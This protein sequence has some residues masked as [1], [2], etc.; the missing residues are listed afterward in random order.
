MKVWHGYGSEHSH[1]LVLI[2]TFGDSESASEAKR[3]IDRLKSQATAEW[4]QNVKPFEHRF[5]DAMM[6]ILSEENLMTVSPEE[7]EQLAYD[8]NVQLDGKTITVTTDEID[9]FGFAKVMIHK[10]ASIQMYSA[11]DYPS[12]PPARQDN[13]ND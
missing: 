1:R 2:G 12:G 13:S 11:H 10:G 7:M 9:V 5:T 8:I 6:A 3:I 4:D